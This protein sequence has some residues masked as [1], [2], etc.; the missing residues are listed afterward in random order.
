MCGVAGGGG[1]ALVDG[2]SM[3][4]FGGVGRGKVIAGGGGCCV[5]GGGSV[6]GAAGVAVGV[7]AGAL[8]RGGSLTVSL[9]R[10]ESGELVASPG[11]FT[12]AWASEWV[13]R[14]CALP[15]W[16]LEWHPR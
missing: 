11:R 2:G 12:S 1:S 13:R 7:A 3:G 9:G 10:F 6:V 8:S 14:K 5:G 4:S 16:P 15:T